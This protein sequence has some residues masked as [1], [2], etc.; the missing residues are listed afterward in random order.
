MENTCNYKY[1]IDQISFRE[2]YWNI[3]DAHEE[4]KSK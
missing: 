1:L 3:D 2:F 4:F